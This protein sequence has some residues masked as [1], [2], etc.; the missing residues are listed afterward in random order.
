MIS[1]FRRPIVLAAF[2]AIGLLGTSA[3]ADM[4]IMV[5]ENSGPI[6]TFTVTGSPSSPGGVFGAMNFT[7]PDYSIGFLSG[8]ELQLAGPPA[9]SELQSATVSVTN[10]TG[11]TGD[12]LH[13]TVT[14]NGYTAPT[15][16]PDISALS[17]IGATFS[18]VTATD[19][20]SFTSSVPGSTPTGPFTAQSTTFSAPGSYSNDQSATITGLTSP[21]SITETYAIVLNEKN[22]TIN[23]SGSTTLTG[24][25]IAEPSSLTLAGLSGLC[26][27][28]YGLRRRAR[29]A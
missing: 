8:K 16:P 19:S 24:H 15:A 6:Q 29:G 28:G 26:L 9:F 22:D 4:I 3:R 12:V 23:F 25:A 11:G 21:Y 7:T 2:V 27:I 14:G 5:Q 10:T 20:L 18:I 13:I 1:I 17:H